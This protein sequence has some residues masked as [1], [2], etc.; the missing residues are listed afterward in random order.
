MRVQQCDV[1]E[2]P[3]AL[4]ILIKVPLVADTIVVSVILLPLNVKII[5]ILV[6]AC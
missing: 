3:T 4:L 1:D 2:N 5:V 6:Y